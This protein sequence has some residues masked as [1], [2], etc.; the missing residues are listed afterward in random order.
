MTTEKAVWR[1]RMRYQTIEHCGARKTKHRKSAGTVANI[2]ARRN[3][4]WER[5]Q[6]A[7]YRAELEDMALSRSG[8]KR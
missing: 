2:A 4:R 7:E 1:R 8:E 6:I 5:A 3:R